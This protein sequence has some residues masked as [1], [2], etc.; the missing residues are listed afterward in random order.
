MVKDIS[1]VHKVFF[2]H[3]MVLSCK[4]GMQKTDIVIVVSSRKHPN[5][6]NCGI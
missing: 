6:E 2:D 3:I 1:Y 4:V 5:Y